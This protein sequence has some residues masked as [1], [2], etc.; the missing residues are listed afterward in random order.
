MLTFDLEREDVV[1]AN[2]I[3]TPL[4]V[5]D[6]N[7][8]ICAQVGGIFDIPSS[9][10]APRLLASESAGPIT[11]IAAREGRLFWVADSGANRLTI[12]TLAVP[13]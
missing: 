1:A 9:R 4:A 12:R 13:P 2:A 5:S 6:S 10:S 11:A 8:V 3:C 7:T